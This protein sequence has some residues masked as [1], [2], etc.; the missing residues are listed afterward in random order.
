M[1]QK[2]FRYLVLKKDQIKIETKLKITRF[3]A[4]LVNF[5]IFPKSEA[6]NCLKMLLRN[7]V[8]HQVEMACAF[9][10]TCGR[11]LYRSS[12][13]HRRMKIY[14]VRNFSLIH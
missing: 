1:L 8:H 6:F 5:A 4:E 7:F 9:V 10:E 12:D 11:Y 3:I 2:D 14:L 13:S